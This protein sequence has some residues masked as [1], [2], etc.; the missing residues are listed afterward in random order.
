[1]GISRL[2]SKFYDIEYRFKF[3]TII[4]THLN[5]IVDSRFSQVNINANFRY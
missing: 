2:N 5:F 1:M 3:R 4:P